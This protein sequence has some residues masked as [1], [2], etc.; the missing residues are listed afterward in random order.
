MSFAGESGTDGEQYDWVETWALK[1]DK[2]LA[3]LPPSTE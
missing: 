2:M 1:Q 3:V